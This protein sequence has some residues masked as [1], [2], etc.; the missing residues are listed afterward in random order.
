MKY[1]L[2]LGVVFWFGEFLGERGGYMKF[3]KK[4]RGKWPKML[5]ILKYVSICISL[6]KTLKKKL[7]KNHYH[8]YLVWS[9]VRK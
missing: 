9:R 1:F 8:H 4:D 6:K 7:I 5:T 2:L 3:C